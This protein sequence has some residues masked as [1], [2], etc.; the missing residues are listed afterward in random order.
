MAGLEPESTSVRR[1]H[2]LSGVSRV[3]RRR[4]TGFALPFMKHAVFHTRW[5]RPYQATSA[6]GADCGR[7]PGARRSHSTSLLFLTRLA[8][9][10][11]KRRF[12]YHR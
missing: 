2:F 8:N 7:S 9:S 6:V 10:K 3:F 5:A 4:I 11:F 1:S 12:L